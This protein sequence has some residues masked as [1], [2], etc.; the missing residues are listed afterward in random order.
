ML[1]LVPAGNLSF[2]PKTHVH[3]ESG[4]RGGYD[5]GPVP[6]VF[7]Y[8]G[9]PAP[10][11]PIPFPDGP[12]PMLASP[13]PEE[14]GQVSDRRRG[15][16][17]AALRYQTGVRSKQGYQLKLPFPVDQDLL[18]V[19]PQSAWERM[20]GEY[21]TM[22]L[23]PAGHVMAHLRRHLAESVA[24]SNMMDGFAEGAAATVAGLVIRRQHPLAKAIFLTLEDE[25]GH[26]PIIVWLDVYQRYKLLFKEPF[27][28][29][30]GTVSRRDGTFNIIAEKAETFRGNA[31]P[32]KAKSWR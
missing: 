15:I 12:R 5:E 14:Y 8:D 17:E 18:D 19:P 28:I 1:P 2:L 21:R 32:P 10:S 16:Q 22:G 26:I 7:P 6:S 11:P 25:F 4:R 23:F 29:V 13:G 30:T 27:V 3:V 31:T 20:E 24:P 9:R